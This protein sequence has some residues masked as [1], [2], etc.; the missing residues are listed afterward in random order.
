M[1]TREEFD[2]I[3]VDKDGFITKEEFLKNAEK[4]LAQEDPTLK[5]PAILNGF[6]ISQTHIIFSYIF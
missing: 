4:E 5:N 6:V 2:E 1:G 3:D